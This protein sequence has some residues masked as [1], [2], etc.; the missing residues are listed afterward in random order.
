MRVVIV[1]GVAAGP[2]TAAR[3]VRVCPDAQVTIVEKGEFMSYA[4]CGLPYYI[5]GVVKEQK[6]LMA[7]PTGVVRD[8][9]FFSKVKNIRVLNH[10]EAV[11]IDR[12][13]KLVMLKHADGSGSSLEYDKLVLAT[14][15]SPVKPPIPGIGLDNIYSLQ[16]IEDAEAI[17]G[18]LRQD[19]K[20]DAVIVGGGLIGVEMAEALVD[21]GCRVTM[22]EL[23]PQVLAMLDPEMAALVQKHLEAK[24]VKVMTGTKVTGFEGDGKVSHVNTDKGAIDA[25]MVIMAIG[26][27]PNAK[28]AAEAGLELGVCGTIK[29]DDTMRTSAPDIYSAGDCV[30]CKNIITGKNCYVPLG[31][32]ANKQGRVAA[33]NICGVEDHF[34]GIVGSAICKVFDFAAARTGLGEREAE[35]NGYD[36]VTCLAPAPDKPHFM[37]TA[38]PLMLKLI[39]DRKSGRLLGAQAVGPG[40]ADKRM[41]VAATA[42][43]AGLTVEQVANLDLCYAP[44]YSPAV[45][46]I[47]TAANVLRN[48]ISGMMTGISSREVKEKLDRGDDFVMLDVRG[49]A[50][51]ETMKI[52][53]CVNIPLGALR[54]RLGELD[55]EREIVT[56]C[57]ISLRGYEAALILKH[58]GFKNVKVM[59]GGVLMWPYKK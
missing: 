16:T 54:D 46:N 30:D 58:A 26:V 56:Y 59:D 32:T 5:S 43:A 27:K 19:K 45:D 20:P 11:A 24:G 44:P 7:T 9:K 41:D 48:K 40:C 13:E 37:P 36:V 47:I 21:C 8:G 18:Q 25:G 17:R 4:G 49:P 52:D 3:I 39:A 29:V 14:G 2:K 22:V 35:E 33:N 23:M 10:T 6:E 1:G 34:H 28:L 50:E 51:L 42:I 53:P 57:K 31:S 55:K 15:A 38:R 12:A